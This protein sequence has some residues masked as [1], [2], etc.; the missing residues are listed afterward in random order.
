M[1]AYVIANVDV[2]DPVGYEEYRTKVPP[3][4]RKHRG[5]FLVRGGQISILE[6]DWRPDRLVVLQFPDRASA[7]AFYDDPEYK[8]LI[9]IRQRNSRGT[10][11]I[12]DGV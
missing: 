4:V 8:P 10:L 6:G 1:P 11:L 9:D 2:L 12:I 3:I 7:Q 5:E